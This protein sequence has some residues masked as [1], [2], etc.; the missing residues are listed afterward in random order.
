MPRTDFDV[1]RLAIYLHLT[2]DKVA[3]LAERAKIPGRKVA[4]QWRFSRAD[5]HHWLE[6]R[7]GLSD[8][9]ELI[10][11]EGVLQRSS[12]AEE[13]I[14][15]VE[16]LP[17]VSE[18]PT[19]TTAPVQEEILAD[20]RR[21]RTNPVVLYTAADEVQEPNRSTSSIPMRLLFRHSSRAALT[22]GSS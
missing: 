10:Q 7:I 13:E 8:E 11:M 4:G 20:L 3:R 5:I 16:M 15:I 17:S 1:E 22:L 9:E 6:Q 2:P 14:S 19:A 21:R 12:G 18:S